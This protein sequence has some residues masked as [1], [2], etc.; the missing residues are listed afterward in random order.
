MKFNLIFIFFVAL[1]FAACDNQCDCDDVEEVVAVPDNIISLQ[2][3]EVLY[4]DYGSE[5]ADLIER[6]ENVTEE[7]DT[8]PMQDE[9]YKKTTRAVAMPYKELKKYL[10]YIEQ[11]A[12]SA[13]I[14]IVDL[15][16]YFG[17]YP[18]IQDVEGVSK[19]DKKGKETIFI[20]PTALIKVNDSTE[21]NVSYALI[22][23]NNGTWR[24]ASVGSILKP[25]E[26]DSLIEG[27]EVIPMSGNRGN[28]IPPPYNDNNDF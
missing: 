6:I 10:T 17:K 27:D 1:S 19:K 15:R 9:R 5:R 4:N 16:F 13:N 18:T 12:D 25:T 2:A 8:I 28:L 22:K 20:N 7:G 14:E 11:Q 21:D 3:A 24:A 23:S 26:N